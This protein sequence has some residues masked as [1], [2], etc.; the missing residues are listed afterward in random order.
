[1]TEYEVCAFSFSNIMS[2]IT[3]KGCYVFTPEESDNVSQRPWKRRKT[4]PAKAPAKQ[5]AELLFAP[6]L[7]GLEKI[8]STRIRFELFERAWRP[9]EIL[10]K[11]HCSF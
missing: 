9:K 7:K 8:E 2:L 4:E 10:L 1:M 3:Q 6:L 11:V 5:N